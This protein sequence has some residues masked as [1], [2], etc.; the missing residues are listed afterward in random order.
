L[1]GQNRAS[2]GQRIQAHEDKFWDDHA[3]SRCGT[4]IDVQPPGG[5]RGSGFPSVTV[6]AGPPDR[7]AGRVPTAHL[8]KIISLRLL[9]RCSH[10]SLV[11]RQPKG[12]G[13][14]AGWRTVTDVRH[15]PT[16]S[17]TSTAERTP[18]KIADAG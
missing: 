5:R 7:Q 13:F 15:D 11:M 9:I 4:L 18:L 8:P 1:L 12:C 17:V 10:V 2:V 16:I 6:A 14:V 3:D